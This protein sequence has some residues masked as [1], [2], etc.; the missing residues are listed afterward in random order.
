MGNWEGGNVSVIALLE[1][2]EKRHVTKMVPTVPSALGSCHFPQAQRLLLAEL[3]FGVVSC[4]CLHV[5]VRFVF[6]ILHKS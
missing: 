4:I 2:R 1:C 3:N 6:Q 5:H